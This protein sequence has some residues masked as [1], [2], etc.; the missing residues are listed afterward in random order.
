M[1]RINIGLLSHYFN[2]N[3]LGCVALSICNLQLIEKAAKEEDITVNFIIYVNEKQPHL[4][5]DYVESPYEYRVYSSSKQSLK[6]P[7]K[8]LTTDIFNDCDIAFNLCA[9]DGFTDIYGFGRVL[10]ESYMTVLAHN[11]GVKM[12]LAPQTIGPFNKTINRKIATSVLKKC[13]TIFT[14]DERSTLFC[15]E[16][17]FITPTVQEVI[18][19]AF[20]LPYK[21]IQQEHDAENIGINVSG[22]L[23]QGGYNHDNYFNLSFSY[24]DYTKLLIDRL[25][26]NGKRVH[27]IAHVVTQDGSIED[28]YQICESL[29]ASNEKIILMP[30][31]ESPIEVKNYI[32]GMDAFIG[33]RMHSTI[34]A[35]SS[36]VPVVP[37]AYSRKFNG[38]FDTLN[39]P[40]YIDAK[41]AYSVESAVSK[42]IEYI[43][44]KDVLKQ[45]VID[46]A[47]IYNERID[48]YIDNVKRLLKERAYTSV[49]NRC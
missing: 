31:S 29:A 1:E 42:T 46:G 19:V 41:G 33:A 39:Y 26:E 14:R 35:F 49:N 4:K 2:D 7:W 23:Y 48:L 43:N 37:V 45:K 9:G 25:I 21:A 5:L 30:R 15:K 13:N 8:L 40:Y 27:L 44:N 17:G 38:L 36:G 22:L 11:K 10:S 18:D 6:H 3:N 16:L 34:G 24:K 47:N 32:A 20:A 28:D 12:I